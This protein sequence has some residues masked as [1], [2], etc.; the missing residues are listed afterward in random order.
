MYIFF[1]ISVILYVDEWKNCK[2]KWTKES[3][4]ESFHVVFVKTYKFKF[5]LTA[6]Y[7]S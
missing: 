2:E 6:E 3:C 1:S 7:I 5:H 4:K